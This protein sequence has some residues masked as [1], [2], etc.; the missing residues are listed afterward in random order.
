[1]PALLLSRKGTLVSDLVVYQLGDAIL[2]EMEPE[3]LTPALE[4]LSH[5]LVSEDVTLGDATD[6]EA[7]F[8]VEGPRASKLLAQLLA[9]QSEDQLAELETLHFI[10]ASHGE[11]EIRVSA[12]RHGPGTAFDLAVPALGAA[13]FLDVLIDAGR[14]LGLQLAGWQVQEIRRIEA[15]IPL[16]GTDMDGS[17]LPLEAGLDDAISFNKGC[18]IGQEY[19]V[20]LAHRGHVTRK[21]TGLTLSGRTVP[22]AGDPIHASGHPSQAGQ[23]GQPEQA[24]GRVTSA[25]FSPS[26]KQPIAMGYLKSAF[27]EPETAVS[28]LNGENALDARVT[29]L[30]FIDQP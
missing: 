12:A 7:L 14:P 10:S 11:R 20:R 15:G 17:H 16:L 29:A 30:P 24:V 26:L 28:I 19:V 8:S 13:E 9:G 27:L 25:A 2:L 6:E 3:G 22:E 5:Y 18:Y 4:S 21:L 23:A 1:M